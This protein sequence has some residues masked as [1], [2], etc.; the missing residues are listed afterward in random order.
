MGNIGWFI[1]LYIVIGWAIDVA[2][3]LVIKIYVG[4][5]DKKQDKDS[6]WRFEKAY[7]ETVNETDQTNADLGLDPLKMRFLGFVLGRLFWP[8]SI[9]MGLYAVWERLKS[10]R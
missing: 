6:Y 2:L 10:G 5:R 3:S 8:I 4:I 9:P 1:L 7:N